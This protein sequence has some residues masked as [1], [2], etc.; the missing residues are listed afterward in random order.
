[1]ANQSLKVRIISPRGII[2]QG[3]ATALSSINSKGPFDILPQHAN[4]IT[5]I[6]QSPILIHKTDRT[7][8][9]FTFPLAIVYFENNFATIYTDIQLHE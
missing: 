3:E 8:Q 9:T 5:L 2:F 7:M 1:M 4:I 6:E